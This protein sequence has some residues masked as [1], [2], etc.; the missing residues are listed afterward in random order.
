MTS[1]KKL[2]VRGAIWTIAGYGTAQILRFGS[3]LI[4][5][6]LL[7]P[8]YFGL[9]AVVNTLRAGIDLFSDIGIP[10]SIIH[11][12]RGD[13]P[14]FLNTAWTLQVIRGWVLW[15]IFL[16]ITLPI[17][18][19]YNDQRLLWLIPFVGLSSVFDGFGS[20]AIHTLYR[21][22]DL[23]KLTKFDLCIQVLSLATLIFC[24]WL[25]PSMLALAIGVVAGSIYRM[26]G[27]HWLIPG[28]SNR[29]AWDRDAVKEIVSFGRWMFVATGVTFLNEQADRLILAKLLAFRLLGV[30]TIAYSL[31]AIPREIVKNLSY[32][33]I[34]PTISQQ[35]DLPRASLLSKILRQRQII[36][37]G[38]AMLL[39]TLVTVGD[40]V[41]GVLYDQR[42]VEATW[43]MP[44][45][46]CG[47]WFSVLYYTISP[48]LLAIGKPLYSAQSNLA[49][50][51]MIGLGLP[52][53][54]FHFGTVGAIVVIAV[55]D[56]PLYLVNLYALW[57]EQLFCLVQDIQSTAFFIIILTL[58]LSIRN[59]LGFGLPIQAL[60]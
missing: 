53:A 9:M 52:I 18:N 31:A 39:A 14:T 10:Q 49:G 43:M 6:R 50:F 42:Y 48:A 8:E 28:Y 3:N 22:I 4:L 7:V 46:C 20:N 56:L 45:L 27:S 15:L 32:K 47:I 25:S 23:G 44:I 60:F 12:K 30:Y 35:I 24:A 21:R 57:R 26:V 16:L 5:T 2:A 29:F 11:N 34:F 58:L 59:H 19:L 55:S 33:V 17:A 38:F 54:F 51:V 1:V 40:L 37:L 41:I 36:L 13:E